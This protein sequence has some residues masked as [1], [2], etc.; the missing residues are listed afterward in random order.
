MF[1]TKYSYGVLH[2]HRHAI[3]LGGGVELMTGCRMEDGDELYWTNLNL[4]AHFLWWGLHISYP[5]GK[6]RIRHRPTMHSNED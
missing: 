2:Y 5:I 1:Q 3:F 6:V 4:Q